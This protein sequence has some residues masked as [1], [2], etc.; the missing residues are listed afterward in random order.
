MT[1]APAPV[2]R[3]HRRSASAP[4]PPGAARFSAA[5]S[6]SPKFTEL[7]AAGPRAGLQGSPLHPPQSRNGPKPSGKGFNRFPRPI[8]LMAGRHVSASVVSKLPLLDIWHSPEV[9][10]VLNGMA[11]ALHAHLASVTPEPRERFARHSYE[12]F[13]ERLYPLE[14]DVDKRALANVPSSDAVRSF[15]AQLHDQLDIDVSILIV[16]LIF[17]ERVLELNAWPLLPDTWR[18]MLL[19]GL[20]AAAKV[21]FDELVWNVDMTEA[22]PDWNLADINELELHF[23]DRMGYSFHVRSS[24]YANF[25]F[26]LVSL[27]RRSSAGA[28]AA[29]EAIAQSVGSRVELKSIEHDAQRHASPLKSAPLVVGVASRRPTTPACACASRATPTGAAG[30]ASKLSAADTL[31]DT[32]L[33][34]MRRLG[35]FP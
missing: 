22:F 10:A 7:A 14:S 35:S 26:S 6:D 27:E 3:A 32:P 21:L 31:I 4:L 15:L 30:A 28:Q 18:R 19:A 5:S 8:S 9:D 1:P 11:M 12:R 16:T 2:A 20:L 34:L 33:S 24:T 13:S 25:Y 17:V 29:R 23:C